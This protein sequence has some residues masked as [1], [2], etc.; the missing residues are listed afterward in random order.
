LRR[1]AGSIEPGMPGRLGSRGAGGGSA[2]WSKLRRRRLD[3]GRAFGTGRLAGRFIRGP[4]RFGFGVPLHANPTPFLGADA[5][6]ASDR[7]V[8]GHPHQAQYL[9][10]SHPQEEGCHP[11][12]AAGC[13][14]TR[15][16]VRTG[17]TED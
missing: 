6:L 16:T 2:R 15:K 10:R 17:V 1:A 3:A 4:R 7:D 5:T 8:T 11:P 14:V 9:Q 12:N 13:R